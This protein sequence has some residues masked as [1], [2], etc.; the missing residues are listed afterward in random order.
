MSTGRK[1]YENRV[2]PG[3]I[4]FY[5]STVLDFVRAFERPEMKEEMVRCLLRDLYESG[6]LLHA[7][8]VMPH[9]IHF[10]ARNSEEYDCARLM[11]KIKRNSA[12][13]LLG[14]LNDIEHSKFDMQRGLN[15][16]K[17][18]RASYRSLPL[19]TGAV[20]QQKIDYVHFNPVKG[21]LCDAAVDY[22]W[23]SAWLWERDEFVAEGYVLNLERVIEEFA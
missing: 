4:G 16:R 9:H 17:F 13:R 7:F 8:V 3:Q 12:K 23:S 15:G 10:V 6:S 2:Q 20:I 5:T 14:Q 22:R 1:H 11:N 19:F 21:G 18:W